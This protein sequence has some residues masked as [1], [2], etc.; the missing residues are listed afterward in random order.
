MTVSRVGCLGV[1]APQAAQTFI[2]LDAALG[3]VSLNKAQFL[4][5][6]D[7]C[8]YTRNGPDVHQYIARFC[9]P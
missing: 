3:G 7:T 4:I 6:A 8:I 9:G 5:A 1:T 2:P